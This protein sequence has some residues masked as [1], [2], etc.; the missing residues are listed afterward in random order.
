MTDTPPEIRKLQGQII[1]RKPL[2]VRLRMV[3]EMMEAG[4]R[5]IRD[6]LQRQHP[7]LSEGERKAAIFERMYRNDFS[8]EEM[9]RIKASFL[10]F[11]QKNAED[12]AQSNRQNIA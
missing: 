7:N 1:R 9:A 10:A 5:M 3:F 2:E 4:Q 8:A 11:H 12:V 6:R